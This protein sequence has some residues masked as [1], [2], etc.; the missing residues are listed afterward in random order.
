MIFYGLLQTA[1]QIPLQCSQ[2]WSDAVISHT[3]SNALISK[4]LHYLVKSPL[5]KILLGKKHPCVRL[6]ISGGCSKKHKTTE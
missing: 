4:L 2:M 1:A 5:D 3:G 6:K